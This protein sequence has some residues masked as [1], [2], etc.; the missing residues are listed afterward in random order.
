MYIYRAV[1]S[2]DWRYPTWFPELSSARITDIRIGERSTIGDGYP[3]ERRAKVLVEQA[4]AVHVGSWLTW[5]WRLLP[6]REDVF[7]CSQSARKERDNHYHCVNN[8]CTWRAPVLNPLR[9]RNLKNSFYTC[10][11]WQLDL[12]AFTRRGKAR[13]CDKVPMGKGQT[14]HSTNISAKEGQTP[15]STNWRKI[16]ALWNF[17]RCFTS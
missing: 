13:T 11:Q 12:S 5:Y 15:P 3:R 6:W 8:I 4:V 7:K 10:A 14:S 9:M 1:G 16:S 17:V 2:T